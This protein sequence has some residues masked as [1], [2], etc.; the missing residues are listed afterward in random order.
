MPISGRLD[1]GLHPCFL[2]HQLLL[3]FLPFEP[4]LLISS[5]NTCTGNTGRV[6]MAAVLRIEL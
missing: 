5:S 6:D 2:H 4:C 3:R 1:P